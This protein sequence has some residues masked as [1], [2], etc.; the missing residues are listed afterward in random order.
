MPWSTPR[1]MAA[2]RERLAAAGWRWRELAT[3][4]DIDEPADLAH[5][6]P[7]WT[8][9]VRAVERPSGMDDADRPPIVALR[10]ALSR[11]R[12]SWADAPLDPLADKGLAHHH[13]R[14][15]GSGWL[16]RIPKQSQMGLPAAEA[17]AYEAACY[18]RAAASGHVPHVHAVLPPSPELPRGAL[19][20]DE[21][22][23]RAARLPEDLPAIAAALA[24]IHSLPL[25]QARAPLLDDADPLAALRTE[26]DRQA[27][28]L[29]AAA[30]DA[31]ARALIEHARADFAALT[32][33]PERPPR[34]LIA[35]DGHPGNFLIRADGRAMLVDIEKARY[36]HP[37]LDLAHATL[38][39]STT[40]DIDS[41]A[42]LSLPEVLGFYEVWQ[43]RCDIGSALR[44]WFVPLRTAMWLWS[45][46]WCAKWRVLSPREA[47]TGADG[48]DWSRDKSSAALI[49]HVRDRVDDYLSLAAVE[50]VTCE[51]DA[52]R[53]TLR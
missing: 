9:R 26:I 25:P 7:G 30:L 6:P 45:V 50:R 19:L 53:R 18:E 11:A 14:L 47:R 34:R 32:A 43:S 12:S 21:V 16:A 1:V 41:R 17:L 5:L 3:R 23:G 48:E 28:H 35:F 46:T 37:P 29:D 20:V 8:V 10:A 4:H 51:F 13:V 39:T 31:P 52:L 44:P 2:T 15:V 33:R 49:A 22:A 36:S 42:E 38:Y 27:E 40:W 24:A